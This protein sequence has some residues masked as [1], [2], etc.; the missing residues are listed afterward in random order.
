MEKSRSGTVKPAPFNDIRDLVADLAAG[1]ELQAGSC[2]NWGSSHLAE[3]CAHTLEPFLYRALCDHPELGASPDIRAELRR[4][5]TRSAIASMAGEALLK[6]ILARFAV[7]Q[8]PVVFLKGAYLGAVVYGDPALRPMCDFDLLIRSWNFRRA[9]CLLE[10]M[11]FQIYAQEPG[12][13]RW[14]LQPALA[15]VRGGPVPG[16]VDLHWAIW[17]MNYYRLPSAAVWKEVVRNELYGRQVFFLSPELNFIHLALHTLNHP[18]QIRNRLDLGLM[19]RRE[20][21][22]WERLLNLAERLHV[23]R[24]LHWACRELT[25]SR[26]A[27]LPGD[28]GVALSAYKPARME[29]LV[30]RDPL[31]YVWRFAARVRS[32][33]GRRS[34]VRYVLLRLFPPRE[35]REAV[36]GRSDW[37]SYVKSKLN[38]FRRLFTRS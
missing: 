5:Y 14:A 30:I 15:Y 22:S 2:T 10:S 38:F 1:R 29:D 12:G 21:L 6:Q 9:C 23:M 18:D 35:Y 3:A 34:R 31:R 37:I 25:R 32:L 19:A 16:V 36:L 33:P 26:Y 17:S 20:D 28:V 11:G 7:E 8:I 27:S 24:P 13:F 4:G